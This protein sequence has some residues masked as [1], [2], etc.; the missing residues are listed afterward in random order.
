MNRTALW[1]ILWIVIILNACD[2]VRTKPLPEDYDEIAK[3]RELATMPS[4]FA[5]DKVYSDIGAL[6]QM[7]TKCFVA[8]VSSEDWEK[9]KHE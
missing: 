9:I 2:R 8:T 3:R 6:Q 4:S 1:S 7:P 5:I